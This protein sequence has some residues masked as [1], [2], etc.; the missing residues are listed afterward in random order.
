MKDGLEEGFEGL[1]G[2]DSCD[3]L[4]TTHFLAQK[5]VHHNKNVII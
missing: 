1:E 5:D 2:G 4:E 3:E